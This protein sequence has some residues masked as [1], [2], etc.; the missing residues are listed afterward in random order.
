M[1]T[2]IFRAFPNHVEIIHQVAA[3]LVAMRGCPVDATDDELH[4][5]VSIV[6]SASED[7]Y[8]PRED[9]GCTER[10]IELRNDA[11]AR[12]RTTWEEEEHERFGMMLWDAEMARLDKEKK[13]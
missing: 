3:I 2:N 8:D 7:I 9:Y 6:I 4:W 5:K 10:A 13:A 1:K 12:E 11:W